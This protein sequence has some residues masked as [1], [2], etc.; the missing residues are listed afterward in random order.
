MSC[1][2]CAKGLLKY[3]FSEYCFW[4]ILSTCF[5]FCFCLCYCYC[6]CFF[7]V[8]FDSSSLFSVLLLNG[9]RGKIATLFVF[10]LAAMVI[11]RLYSTLPA[12]P[13]KAVYNNF[14]YWSNFQL[15]SHIATLSKP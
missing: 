6:Y 4:R 15:P 5:C 8:V 12:R 13:I 10:T 3:S 2:S 11:K 14:V 7:S 9:A 1:G